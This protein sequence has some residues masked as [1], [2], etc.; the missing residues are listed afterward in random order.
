E[1]R[2]E[3]LTRRYSFEQDTVVLP[4]AYAKEM[5]ANAKAWKFFQSQPPYYRKMTTWWV[6]SAKREDTRLKRLAMLVRDSA[7]GE[8]IEGMRRP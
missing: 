3:D 5:R 1:R 2:T 8:R 7:A 6:I 4:A